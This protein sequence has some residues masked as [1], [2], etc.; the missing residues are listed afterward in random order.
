MSAF[1]DIPK[2]NYALSYERL[3]LCSTSATARL[4][5]N[6]LNEETYVFTVTELA[7]GKLKMQDKSLRKSFKTAERQIFDQKD[8][9]ISFLF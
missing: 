7:G 9:R 6:K 4:L 3:F 5:Y 8:R 1:V 2:S